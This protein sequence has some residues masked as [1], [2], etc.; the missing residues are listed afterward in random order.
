MNQYLFNRIY[1]LTIGYPNRPNEARVF[2]GLRCSFDITK[3]E[4][5]GSNSCTV[6]INNLSDD[7]RS[8]IK[9]GTA[10]AD[11]HDGMTIILKAGYEEMGDPA[12][13]PTIFTG[14]IMTSTH[15]TTKPEI[16]TTLACWDA[17]VNL[18]TSHFNGSYPKGAMISQ[19]MGDIVSSLSLNLQT[20]IPQ[21][22]TN[23]GILD[24][25]IGW[26]WAYHGNAADALRKCC[27]RMGLRFSVQNNKV[28]IYPVKSKKGGAGSDGTPAFSAFLIGSPKRMAKMQAGIEALDFGGYDFDVLL[29][30]LA[31]PGNTVNLIASSIENSPVPLVVSEAHHQA[32][33]HGDDWKTSIKGRKP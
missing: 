16:E 32:D 8:F 19:I 22:L 31:E 10:A 3:S 15:D 33:T 9:E 12:N 23:N 18:K 4:M 17:A 20:P 27:D 6:K 5:P 21:V 13:L 1:S 11:Y 25:A 26:Q 14:N 7:S 24:A 29:C 30:P 2:S 28:K